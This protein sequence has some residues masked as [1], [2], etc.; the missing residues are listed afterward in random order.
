M[1][2]TIFGISR[3]MKVAVRFHQNCVCSFWE[4]SKYRFWGATHVDPLRARFFSCHEQNLVHHGWWRLWSSF[5]EIMCVVSEKRA[6]T[7]FGQSTPLPPID[8]LIECR[9]WCGQCTFIRHPIRSLL[10]SFIK[11]MRLVQAIMTEVFTD[12]LTDWLTDSLTCGHCSIA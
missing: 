2:G 12:S 1:P 5:I 8:A 7:Y 6:N 9:F 10:P 4:E 3:V 11:I